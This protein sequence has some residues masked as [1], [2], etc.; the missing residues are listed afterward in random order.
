[1]A[2]CHF[3]ISPFSFCAVENQTRLSRSRAHSCVKAGIKWLIGTKA[4]PCAIINLHIRWCLFVLDV[5]WKCWGGIGCA[6]GDW[7]DWRNNNTAYTLHFWLGSGGLGRYIR[8][9]QRL[10]RSHQSLRI[11]WWQTHPCLHYRIGLFTTKKKKLWILW[12]NFVKQS[13]ITASSKSSSL[14]TLNRPCSLRLH[15]ILPVTYERN[16]SQWSDKA[17]LYPPPI[18]VCLKSHQNKIRPK[19]TIQYAWWLITFT[20]LVS[21]LCVEKQDKAKYKKK[22]TQEAYVGHA[23]V[24]TGFIIQKAFQKVFGILRVDI[25]WLQGCC[26]LKD[27]QSWLHFDL[28]YLKLTE[29]IIHDWGKT[30]SCLYIW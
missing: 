20:M 14:Y 7:Q 1:M 29:G 26:G 23:R 8:F 2:K 11:Y 27:E 16:G 25:F 6:D 13:G 3:E 17:P 9:P 22:N 4:S 21:V 10:N 12:L 30:V 5:G 28:N 24:W 19:C 15:L 18:K